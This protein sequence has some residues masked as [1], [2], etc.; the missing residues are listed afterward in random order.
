MDKGSFKELENVRIKATYNMELGGRTIEENEVI[1]YFDRIQIANLNEITDVVTANG[2]YSNR[3]HVFWET[4]KEVRFAFS[5]GIFSKDQFA[6]MANAKL[7]KVDENVPIMLSRREHV[8]SDERGFVTLKEVPNYP[9]FIY[10]YDT[11]MPIKPFYL[12]GDNTINIARQYVDTIVDYNWQYTG[13]AQYIQIGRR[14]LNGFVSLVGETRVKDDT[15]GQIVT[16]ILTIPKLRLMSDLSI[17]LGAQANPVVASF[18]A[19]GVPVG[20]RDGSYVA[21]FMYLG[22]DINS[23]L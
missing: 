16:G 20:S 2:G 17:R 5:Q 3:A 10:E 19:V 23:D 14:L 22:E 21:E 6:L 13:G 12:N 18:N 4:T 1:L 11:G 15:T 7:F 8:E 9:V